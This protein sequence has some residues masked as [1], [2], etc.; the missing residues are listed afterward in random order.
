MKTVDERLDGLEA[1]VLKLQERKK[2]WVDV[3]G[4]L[5]GLLIPAAIAWTGYVF[6]ESQKQAEIA[7]AERL[8]EAQREAG[9]VSM[10]PPFFN[11]LLSADPRRHKLAVEAVLIALPRDGPRLV[12]A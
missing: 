7:S 11:E 3:V 4:V 12:R 6:S 9:D 1:K 5:G 8:A 2:D 10:V